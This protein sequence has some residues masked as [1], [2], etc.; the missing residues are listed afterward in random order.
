MQGVEEAHLEE[1]GRDGSRI[2]GETERKILITDPEVHTLTRHD[3]VTDIHTY[4]RS[5]SQ[6]GIYL[7]FYYMVIRHDCGQKV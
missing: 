4:I 5:R 6:T 1:G 2:K 3:S 7:L